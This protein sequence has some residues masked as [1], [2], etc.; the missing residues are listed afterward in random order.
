M[1][2]TTCGED[3]ESRM[4][5]DSPSMFG[6]CSA[7][8]P[9]IGGLAV[10]PESSSCRGIRMSVAGSGI[11]CVA[12]LFVVLIAMVPAARAAEIPAALTGA[13]E[14]D[15][16]KSDELPEDSI[17]FDSAPASVLARDRWKVLGAETLR[18]DGE[19]DAIGIQYDG[20]HYDDV[21]LGELETGGWTVQASV[22]R[23]DRLVVRSRRAGVTGVERYSV[24]ESG[25]L[26][27]IRISIKGL[28]ELVAVTRTFR[29][30]A[31]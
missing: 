6:E 17:V 20:S 3:W 9:Q 19:S 25:N 29:R 14:L 1:V 2:L 27:K 4:S 30:V 7:G 26:L 18:I 5:E 12:S 23:R 16:S 13:W 22:A 15:V 31:E 11:A 28:A 8:N 21:M 10:P 24:T